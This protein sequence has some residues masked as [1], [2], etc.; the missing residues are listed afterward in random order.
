[1]SEAIRL[2]SA[3]YNSMDGKG[4]WRD[5]PNS[6]CYACQAS[7]TA[8]CARTDNTKMITCSVNEI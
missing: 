2:T 4:C 8:A 3:I 1:M 7:G 6:T 5:N